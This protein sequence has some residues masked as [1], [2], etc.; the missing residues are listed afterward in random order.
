MV[1]INGA[2]G[3]GTGW[4]TWIPCYSPIQIIHNLKRHLEGKPFLRMI[5]WYKGFR[6]EIVPNDEDYHSFTVRGLYNVDDYKR[7]LSISELPIGKW[8]RDYKTMLEEMAQKDEILD[9][10]EFH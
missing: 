2:E 4:S 9:I 5:P 3:I 8:T 6:G 1:L 10:K 7:K